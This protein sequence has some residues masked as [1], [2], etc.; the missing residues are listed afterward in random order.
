VKF[1]VH[2]GPQGLSMSELKDAWKVIEELGFDW[3]S[4]WDHFY[5]AA[6]PFDAPVFDAVVAQSALAATTQRVRVGCL[7]YC[8]AY[9]HP[10]VLANAAIAIDHLSDGRMEMGCGAGW[11]RSEYEGYGFEFEGPAVRL[12]RLEESVNVI[13]ALWTEETVDFEGEF[14]TLRGARCEP[15]PLQEHPRIWVGV[16]GPRGLAL[17]GRS[18]DGWNASYLS[19]QEVSQGLEIVSSTA[20]QRLECGVNLGFIGDVPEDE[21]DDFLV[22]R[23]GPEIGQAKKGTLAGSTQELVDRVHEYTDAGAGWLNVALRAPIDL[24]E[25]ERFALQ[26]T[27]HFR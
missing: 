22:K 7:V 8:T 20:D 15:K 1:G 4:V 17:A 19:P 13:R 12:R 16:Q 5:A 6:P 25:V 27:P 2:L 10:A 24:N 3:I 14:F 9:R 21:R 11:H 18:A 23:F 26:V